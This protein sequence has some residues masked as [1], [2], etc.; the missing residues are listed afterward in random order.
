MYQ[1]HSIR[2]KMKL[3]FV[4]F[5]PILIYQFAN[6]SAA[7][8]DTMMTGQYHTV[9]LAGVAIATSL[10]NPFFTFLTGI[11]S[12]LVPIVGHHLGRGNRERISSDL[13]QFLYLSLVLAAILF[14]LVLVGARF[15][16]GLMPLE[17][18][19][20]EIAHN[21]LFYMVLGIVPFLLF[22]VFRSFFDALGLT[23]LSMYLMLLVVPFNAFFNYIL[24]YGKF[25]L[26]QMGGAGA[27]LG[28]ALAY[29]L[30]LIVVLLVVAFHPQ[31]CSYKV[32][33]PRAFQ[34]AEFWEGVKLG[35]PVGGAVF[36][37]SGIFNVVGLYMSKFSS[38]VIA[39]HQAA[40]NFATLLYAFPFSVSMAMAII[41]SYEVGAK[42]AHD[43]RTYTRLGRLVAFAFA[44]LTLTFLYVFRFNIAA[45]Y[46]NNRGFIQ[47][48][49]IFL[50]YALCFQFADAFAAPIQG[51]LRGYKDTS[52]PFLIGVFS[53]WTIPLPLGI[54]LENRTN[55]GPYAYWIGLI[56]G[57]AVCG[58]LL[59]RRL[60]TIERTRLK[61]Q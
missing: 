20:V 58:L 1:T 9:D 42:R 47:L 56:A 28:T 48:T 54:L 14:F 53:Y 7:F 60:L 44:C 16:L 35:L 32:F 52:M 15:A 29:W 57:I 6:Y 39:S 17:T 40:M 18:Q 13:W 11:V 12:A 55:L 8:I 34:K 4:I 3:F 43:V 49:A 38:E 51:I 41:I 23:R 10:W 37:E 24:I 46:G 22:S 27:G 25:G 45:L 30:L 59:Q 50:T 2:E 21:Y 36:A 19:V 33:Q 31:I 5:L 61:N 26:P